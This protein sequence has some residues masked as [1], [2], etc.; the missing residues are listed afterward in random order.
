MNNDTLKNK[1]LLVI[2]VTLLTMFLEIGFGILSGSMSLTADGVHMATHVFALSITYAVCHIISKLKDK[3]KIL[4]ALGGYTS[5]L[6]LLATAIGIIFESAHRFIKPHHIS[7]NEAILVTFIGLI[8]NIICIVI[9]SGKGHHNHSCDCHHEHTENLNFK[10]AYLH[11]LADVLTSI[12][13]ILALVLGKYFGL[14]LL[15]PL[16]GMLGGFIILKWAI[17]LLK[18]SFNTLINQER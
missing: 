10:A 8:I 13:A 18:S 4:N 5:A 16:I 15:D 2:I 6:F 7:F 17:N 12:M 9:M 1:T 11:I 14:I 3:E